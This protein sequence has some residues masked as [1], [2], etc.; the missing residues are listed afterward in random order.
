LIAIW[1]APQWS[2]VAV[3]ASAICGIVIFEWMRP[4]YADLEQA[5]RQLGTRARLAL[6]TSNR[7]IAALAC[8]SMPLSGMQLALNNYFVTLGV[9]ELGLSHIEAGAALACA[10]AGGLPCTYCPKVPS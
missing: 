9:R 7:R 1:P 4:A 6:V 10:Q 3:G 8:A 2:Y 5:P